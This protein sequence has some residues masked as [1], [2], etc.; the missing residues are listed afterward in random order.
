MRKHHPVVRGVVGL[1]VVLVYVLCWT[2]GLV[3]VLTG[4]FAASHRRHH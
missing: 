1:I 4:M 3:L 2:V